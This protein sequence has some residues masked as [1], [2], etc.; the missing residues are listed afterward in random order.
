[1]AYSAGEIEFL[2]SLDISGH[3]ED[4]A[5]NNLGVIQFEGTN[6]RESKYLAMVLIKDHTN[7]EQNKFVG[8]IP[9]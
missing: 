8:S 2:G 7:Q 4:Q 9:V 6:F 5:I 3:Y 1:M